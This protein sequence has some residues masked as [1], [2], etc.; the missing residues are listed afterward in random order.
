MKIG[1]IPEYKVDIKDG[2]E[3]LPMVQVKVNGFKMWVEL[4]DP[5]LDGKTITRDKHGSLEAN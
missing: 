5:Y 4:T 3:G 1:E 2:Q